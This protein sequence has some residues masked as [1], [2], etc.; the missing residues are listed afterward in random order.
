MKE[1]EKFPVLADDVK[2]SLLYKYRKKDDI[3]I[4]SSVCNDAY[5]FFSAEFLPVVRKVLN[6]C[7]GKND[8]KHIQ[9]IIAMQFPNMD[10][11]KFVYKIADSNLMQNQA[12]KSVSEASEM[13]RTSLN[14]VEYSIKNL[15]NIPESVYRLLFWLEWGLFL[16][17][18]FF[19]LW[20]LIHQKISVENYTEYL[21]STSYTTGLLWASLFGMLF[22]I[23]H[24]FSHII[25]GL[26]V[27][28]L[29]QKIGFS[30]YLNFIPK[31]YIKSSG[32]YLIG[33][34]KRIVFH[35]SGPASN[36]ILFSFF[37]YLGY[38]FN[39]AF[40]FYLA[41][42]NLQIIIL[43]LQPFSLTDGF[44]IMASL[45]KC[46]NL[47]IR[48]LNML[49]FHKHVPASVGLYVYTSISFVFIVLL[50]YNTSFWL[51]GILG[52]YF[53]YYFDRFLFTAVFTV[54]F[55]LQ[56]IIKANHISS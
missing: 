34:W 23:L 38:R 20:M 35:F 48:F 21:N 44:F 13:H 4:I 56:V 39:C 37:S 31:Y 19:M 25:C 47:R 22:M 29:P 6:L 52:D 27:G 17:S 45:L 9:Q 12:K 11:K 14:I 3:Y 40:F 55:V 10:S 5:F 46:V 26:Y 54:L 7:D 16:L 33:R 1:T 28:V 43:N 42:A 30:L 24:E 50:A 51:T 53:S 49:C 8:I 18:W 36:F 2:I 32:I 15:R 41:F